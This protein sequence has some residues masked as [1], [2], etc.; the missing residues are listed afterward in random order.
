MLALLFPALFIHLLPKE[1]L[2]VKLLCSPNNRMNDISAE[3]LT[4]ITHN[5][6]VTLPAGNLF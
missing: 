3:A 2:I 4:D 6:R 5:K 1:R